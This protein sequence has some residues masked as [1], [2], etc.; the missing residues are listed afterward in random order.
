MTWI[1]YKMLSTDRI[2]S[3][4]ILFGV[5]FTTLLM[6]QQA[7]TFLGVLLNTV[8][9]L[10]DI[11]GA[12]IWVMD[13]SIQFIGD[14]KPLRENELYR[15]RGVAGVAWAVPLFLGTAQAQLSAGNY[16]LFSVVGLDDQTLLGAPEE[17]LL[18]S[19]ADLRRP[20]AI[21]L[22]EGGFRLLFPGQPLRIGWSLEMN[23]HRAEVVGICKTFPPYKT[24]P[25]VFTRFRLALHYAPAERRTLSFILA[26]GEPGL[27][28]AAG[29]PAHPGTN[30]I[31]C[32]D[33]ARPACSGPSAI[34]VR[35]TAIPA[36]FGITG[37]WRWSS[38][39][40]WLGRGS[41]C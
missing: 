18:G 2:R 13:P 14:S 12:D 6:A 26:E 23:E 33:A 5:C 37:R 9:P 41:T 35:R 11:R 24:N 29:L 8:S 7:S 25:I 15:V 3:G 21:V 32:V 1:A 19:A 38:A 30:R 20:D 4:A 31:A 34:Y 16:K 39:A 10:R 28:G 17:F 36:V 27:D 22:D 40:R